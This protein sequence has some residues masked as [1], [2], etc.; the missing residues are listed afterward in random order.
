MLVSLEKA[1]E[2]LM[3]GGYV[4]IATR[5]HKLAIVPEDKADI[6]VTSAEVI[7]MMLY[8][9][10]QTSPEDTFDTLKA[11]LDEMLEQAPLEAA[12]PDPTEERAK[13]Y[14]EIRGIS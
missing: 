4:V 12:K 3:K 6:T 8:V 2:I 5:D 7:N 14:R 1:T 13:R 10:R 9:V 11:Q